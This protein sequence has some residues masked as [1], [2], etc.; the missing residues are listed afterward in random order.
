[1]PIALSSEVLIIL[2][3]AVGAVLLISVLFMVTKKKQQNRIAILEEANALLREK[4]QN[5]EQKGSAKVPSAGTKTTLAVEQIKKIEALESEL[6]KQKRRVKEAKVIAQKATKVKY[7]FLTNMRHEIR[8]PMNSILVFAELLMQ[9]L[10]EKKVLSYA[11]NIFISGKKLL[12]MIDDILELSRMESGTFEIKE[13]AVD[14]KRLMQDIIEE[15]AEDAQR[16]G[17][18]FTLEIDSNLPE[19]L[20]LDATKVKDIISNLVDNAVKFTKEGYVKVKVTQPDSNILNNSIDLMVTVEDSGIGIEEG[21]QERIFEIF[22]VRDN[23]DHIEHRGTGLGLSINKKMA[24]LMNGDV[25]FTSKPLKGSTFRLF[26]KHVEVVLGGS[27]DEINEDNIDFSVIRPEGAKVLVVDE[28]L[29]NRNLIRDAFLDSNI[30]IFTYDNPR[31]AI[32]ILKRRAFDMILIDVDMLSSDDNAVAKVIKRITDAPIVTLTEI[33][34]KDVDFTGCKANIVGHL[35]KPISKVELFKVSLKVLSS[36]KYKATTTRGQEN[37]RNVFAYIDD[38]RIDAFLSDELV[39]LSDLYTKAITTNDLEVIKRF[40]DRL[41]RV[42]SNHKIEPLV[43]Y[44]KKLLND[45]ELFDIDSIS[46]LM[47][48]YAKMIEILKSL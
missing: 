16:K 34:L 12:E 9:E 15:Y 25:T 6:A 22:E 43:K 4:I 13:S 10:K 20:M 17:L 47:P 24:Q 40:A 14:F 30:K 38:S 48:E 18:E 3:V 27:E 37:L 36:D 21:D 46:E 19:S 35:K 33:R 45:I 29:E 42:S 44:A 1:M 11:N 26:L 39:Q 41:L 7:D 8:T 5:Y 31:E 2:G 28:S 32:D 23:V